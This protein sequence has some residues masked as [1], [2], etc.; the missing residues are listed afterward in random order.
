MPETLYLSPNQAFI[1]PERVNSK[2]SLFQAHQTTVNLADNSYKNMVSAQS[3]KKIA[4]A[5]NWLVML[6]KPKIVTIPKTNKRFT[7]HCGLVT[8]SLPTGCVSCSSAMFKKILIPSIL[9]S[10]NH[11]F[12]LR[13][14]IWKLEFQERGAVH[15]HI[16]VDKFIPY[17]WLN[18]KWCLLL[19]KHGLLNEYRDYF[20]SLSLRDYVQHRLNTD[21]KNVRS[22]FSSHLGY[23]KSLVNAYKSGKSKG[24]SR[25]NCTDVHAVKNVS[26]LAAYLSK[27]LTKNPELPVGFKGRFWAASSSLSALRQVK[28][29]L[30][31][32]VLGAASKIM[33]SVSYKFND[34][35]RMVDYGENC[36]WIGS[37]YI[38]LKSKTRLWASPLIGQ[39]FR[40]LMKI[41][42]KDDF[43]GV[44][45]YSYSK[46]N[47][48]TYRFA[49][50]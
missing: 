9:D 1:A 41:Y 17:D 10:M 31:E 19:S 44:P 29:E 25:P 13:N 50:N 45:I 27:Y 28:V 4:K 34:I 36:R 7:Y 18:E 6:A 40:H 37:I 48:V 42:H 15:V 22:R 11:Y 43:E 46:L 14:Y 26:N 30:C 33:E 35:I 23:I 47:G 49:N 5:V 2:R 12:N 24:W 38:L 32:G 21:S 8:L 39:V 16:T 3:I 20:N